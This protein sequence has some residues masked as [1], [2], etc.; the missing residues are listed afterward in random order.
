MTQIVLIT[1]LRMT[2]SHIIF[3]LSTSI[4]RWG[5]KHINTAAVPAPAF[6]ANAAGRRQPLLLLILIMLMLIMMTMLMQK[7]MLL[8]MIM[9]VMMMM[10]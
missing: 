8:M 5:Y 9:M 6:S 4:S 3:W 1:M 7:V 2:Q 10:L